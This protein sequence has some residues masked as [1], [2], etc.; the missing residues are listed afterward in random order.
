MTP[1]EKIS[2]QT[3]KT[4]QHPKTRK[5]Q[6]DEIA[7]DDR[8]Q[9]PPSDIKSHQNNPIKIINKPTFSKDSYKFKLNISYHMALETI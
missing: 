6:G 7:C 5:T 3:H 1:H 4:N 9:G 2:I 8:P